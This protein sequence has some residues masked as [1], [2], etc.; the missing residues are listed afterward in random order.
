MTRRLLAPFLLAAMLLAGCSD[1]PTSTAEADGQTPTDGQVLATASS[2]PA[3]TWE[4]GQWWEWQVSFGTETLPDTFKSIVVAATAGYNLATESTQEAKREA[5]YGRPL[6]GAIGADFSMDGYGGSWQVLSFP[7]TDGKT[8]TATIPNIAWDVLVPGPVEVAMTATFED[9]G[10]VSFMGHVEEGMILEGTYDP[11]TGWFS[12]LNLYDIDPGQ[13]ELEIGFT[14]ANTGTN[15][16]GP[17]FLHTAKLLLELVDGSGFD[18]DPTAG[19][20]PYA[21]TQPQGSF[22]MA[23]DTTLYG[24][25]ETGSFVGVRQAV[26]LAPDGT[27]RR[28]EA[29]GAMDGDWN[30]A[31]FDEPGQAGD[32]HLATAGAGAFTYAAARI[33]EITEGEFSL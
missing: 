2:I 32:W 21:Q 8:W 14:A 6:L 19:G 25:V 27:V 1:S 29:V 30:G 24:W 3:P 12:S 26:L 9:S 4:V 17:Y 13:E 7:L 31:Y 5:A 33:F 11:A 18:D 10:L 23:A 20:Q 15:Y 22:T 16:T 28:A